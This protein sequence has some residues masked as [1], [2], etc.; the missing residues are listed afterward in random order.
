MDKI[1]LGRTNLNVTRISFGALPIQRCTMEEAGP[2]LNAALDA[3]INFVDTARAYTDSEVK[4][5]EHISSRRGEYYLAT[6]SF[7]R[8]KATMAKDIDISLANMRTDHI[9]LYQIH[10]LQRREDFETVMAPGGALEALKEAQAAGKI[11]HIGVTGHSIPLVTE[12]ARTGEFST[13]QVPFNFIETKA[14]EELIP[15]AKSMDI[16]VIAMKPLGGGQVKSYSLAL[17]YLYEQGDT[18]A[19]PGMDEI[20]HI[21]ENLAVT[22]NFTPLT[23]AEKQILA[24]EAKEL[25][26]SFCRR[27]GYCKP[28]TVGID[29]PT[30]FIW[31]L[32]YTRYGLK[33][34]M[35]SR[36]NGLKVKASDCTQCGVCEKRCPYDLPIR[37]RMKT[38]AAEMG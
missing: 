34:P 32:Q 36:Y 2:V 29:I 30:V 16:G 22:K 6:K 26:N 20:A 17:K 1:R 19:I 3:G 5:G 9:D 31:Y 37:E 24:D 11:R 8:D 35:G 27:C 12:A 21:N 14:L 28:C 25:G 33:G 23:A 7:G 10:N 38:I 18:V 4:I 15:L 13:V